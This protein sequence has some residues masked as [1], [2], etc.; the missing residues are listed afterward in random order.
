[1]RGMCSK[2]VG[3]VYM[4]K[5]SKSEKEELKTEAWAEYDKI[6]TECVKITTKAWA[7]YEKRRKEIEKM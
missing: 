5:L 6:R 7:K 4:T 2:C 3:R 1:M